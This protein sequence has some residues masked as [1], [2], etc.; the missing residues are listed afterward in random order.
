VGAVA[1]NKNKNNISVCP[2][3]NVDHDGL[4]YIWKREKA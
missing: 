3:E 4:F 2:F 1:L